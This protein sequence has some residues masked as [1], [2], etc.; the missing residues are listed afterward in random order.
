MFYVYSNL[1]NNMRPNDNGLVNLQ[2]FLA[3]SYPILLDQRFV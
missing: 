2:Y 1:Y 3:T